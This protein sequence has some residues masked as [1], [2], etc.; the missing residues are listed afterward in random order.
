MVSGGNGSASGA[1]LA[2]R[3]ILLAG[4]AAPASLRGLVFAMMVSTRLSIPPVQIALKYDLVVDLGKL[5]AYFISVTYHDACRIANGP[6]RNCRVTQYLQ[7]LP[8]LQRLNR[9]VPSGARAPILSLDCRIELLR[10]SSQPCSMEDFM[11]NRRQVLE[12][13]IAFG[14][15]SLAVPLDALA[16]GRPPVR[17][18]YSEVVRS[19][20]YAPAYV[21]MTKGF[22]RE[23]GLDVALTTAQGGDKSVAALLSNRADIA[24]AGPEVSIY[25]QNSDSPTKIPIFGALTDADGSM[26]VGREKVNNFDW[27]Q[28]KG[29][30]ILAN[31]PGSTPDLFLEAALRKRGI[32]PTRDVKLVNNIAIPARLGAWLAGQTQ[33]AI[34]NEPDASQLE[35]D[36]KAHLLASIGEVV[37][38]L[39]YTTF[40]A[41]DKYI[42]N[43]PQVIQAWIN[44]IYKAQQWTASAQPS[45][46]AKAIDQFFPGMNERALIA[47]VE[48]YRK[49]G[50]WKSTPKIDPSSLDKLQDILVQGRVLES[51]KRVQFTD[52]MR[53]EFGNAA[54]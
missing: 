44:A 3:E 2:V 25:V 21:A 52:V 4:A 8:A 26:L 29:K 54:K 23:A 13:A 30:A 46:I 12:T 45:E 5:L 1:A 37:G 17:V 20:F 50:I 10:S 9:R 47:G 41:T 53:P 48:R 40:M 14:A 43:N 36:G 18:R 32:D 34:F 28:L 22:F 42:R 6:G 31:R 7:A 33:F 27:Q 49:F 39:D 15:Q 24:L 16:Q 11:L 19:I 51:A 35:L 38:H